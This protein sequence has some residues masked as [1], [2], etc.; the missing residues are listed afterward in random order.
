YRGKRNEPAYVVQ[1]AKTLAEVKGLTLEEV[2][3]VTRRNTEML[4]AP[5]LRMV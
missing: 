2:A 4:F 5:R 3:A 1:V